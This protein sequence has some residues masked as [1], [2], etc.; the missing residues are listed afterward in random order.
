MGERSTGHV[1]AVV[2]ASVL[3]G[4]TGT[5]A[6]FAPEGSSPLVIGLSTFG[7]GGI[8]LALIAPWSVVRV[9]RHPAAWRWIVP[10]AIGVV[11]YPTCYYVSMQL[12]GV[13]IGNVVALGSGPILAAVLEWLVERRVP[14][15]RWAV[16]TAIAVA[17]VG[18]L[19][20]G[21][22]DSA[23]G[24]NPLAGIALA[25]VASLGYALYTYAGGRLIR[26]G[27]TSQG[28]M[29]AIFLTGS[30][31][32]VP[33]FLLL[34]PG[35][36]LTAHGPIILLYLAL[37]PM[38]LSY[39]LFGIGLRRLPA[40]TA[41]TLALVE[42]ACATLLAVLVVQERLSATAWVGLA[43]IGVGIVLL[44]VRRRMPAPAVPPS[45]HTTAPRSGDTPLT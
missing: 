12:A 26:D 37:I 9:F 13:A 20:L 18:L 19:V 35:P 45:G 1:V 3:W 29:G 8:I 32:M 33:A 25:L 28:S 2:L 6:H 21:A 31:V 7:F 4:T 30:A 16:A 23:A 27:R 15:R 5:V 43:A 38:A 10:G 17:G 41:T 40:S 44:A 39:V 36:L 34:G 11:L 24:T 14:S 22:E 42:P